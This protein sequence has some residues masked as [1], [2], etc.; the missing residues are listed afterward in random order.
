MIAYFVLATN[1][2]TMPPKEVLDNYKSQQGVERGFRLIKDPVFH[3]NNMFLK[4]L[5]RINALMMVMTFSLMVYNLGQYQ[6]RETLKHT[7]RT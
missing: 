6:F 2:F 4:R 5:E 7:F 1:H 3:L